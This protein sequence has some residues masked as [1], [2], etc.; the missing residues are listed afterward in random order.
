M[1]QDKLIYCSDLL[2]LKKQLKADGYYD[3]ESGTYT[4]NQTLT[5]LKYKDNTSLSYVRGFSLDLSVYIMLEDL[6]SYESILLDDN[7]D[8]LDL[9]KGIYP[10]DTPIEY[11]D[12][13]GDTQTYLPPFKIGSFA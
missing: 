9:Y 7:S 2:A 8:K 4:V 13:N 1:E 5:P 3:E 12:D 6:G 10:F 11:K